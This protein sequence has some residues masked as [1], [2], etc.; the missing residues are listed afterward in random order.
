MCALYIVYGVALFRF[1]NGI[2]GEKSGT[3]VFRDISP[4]LPCCHHCL[5][6]WLIAR[7]VCGL[8]ETMQSLYGITLQQRPMKMNPR[9]TI[10]ADSIGYGSNM[11]RTANIHRTHL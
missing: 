3:S 1:S 4:S 7:L 9:S 11:L 6:P 10:I 8:H 2:L 5:C